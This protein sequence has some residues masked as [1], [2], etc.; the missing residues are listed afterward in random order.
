LEKE[1][2]ELREK[3][4]KLELKLKENEQNY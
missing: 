4:R 2:H 1:G 3:G